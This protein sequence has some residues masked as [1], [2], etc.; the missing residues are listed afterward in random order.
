MSLPT[1]F[2][3]IIIGSK[4]MGATQRFFLGSVASKVVRYSP[5]SVYVVKGSCSCA[6]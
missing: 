5:C 2:F 1:A 3:T 4:G 6:V